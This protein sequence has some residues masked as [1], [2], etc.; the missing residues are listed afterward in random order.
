MAFGRSKKVE[1]PSVEPVSWADV[2]EFVLGSVE[3]PKTAKRTRS[4][5][6]PRAVRVPQ[7]DKD[8]RVLAPCAYVATAEKHS[9]PSDPGLTLYEDIEQ[10]RLLCYL[11]A[12]QDVEG[13]QHHV[14]R[15]AQDQVI[16]TLR[17]VP[18]KR[19]F[20]HTWRIDQPGHPEI[21]G[22]NELASGSA[23]EV[24][25][26]AAS[27]FVTGVFDDLLNP[28]ESDQ[29]SKYRSLEW[30]SGEDVV[31]TSEGSAKINIHADWIDR[32][33]AFAFAL[34]GDN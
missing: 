15:D 23:K 29:S 22:R 18:P 16:G 27:R 30:R 9:F 5:F 26:R 1:E 13:E 28:G 20:K 24:A 2:C 4:G 34:V 6:G 8:M 17:R 25:G 32:R 19:P 3:R 14:V 21:V 10:Q 33:L 12:P 7:G 11:D 31:I